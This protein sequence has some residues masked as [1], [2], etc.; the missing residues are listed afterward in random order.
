MTAIRLRVGLIADTHGLLRPEVAR[1]FAGVNLIVHAGDVGSS[2][3][4]DGLS[5]LAPTE[6]V[7]GNVDDRQDPL[8]PR[9]RTIPL[10]RLVLHVSHGDELGRPGPLALLSRYDADVLV[11][12]HTHRAVVYHGDDGRLVINPGSAGPRRFSS[13]VTVALLTVDGHA[14]S[15][16]LV[17]LV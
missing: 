10:G 15:A 6:A 7:S 17:T 5:R 9:H 13:L 16:E 2:H 3:V 4:L 8:L 1:A 11:F 12:G 14:V